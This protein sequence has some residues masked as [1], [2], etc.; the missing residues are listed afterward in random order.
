MSEAQSYDWNSALDTFACYLIGLGLDT[1]KQ[2]NIS[3]GNGETIWEKCALP[4]LH[5][6]Q[7]DRCQQMRCQKLQ[8]KD[9]ICQE[10]KHRASTVYIWQK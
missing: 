10:Q 9:Q 4:S 7:G 1:N 6:S 5:L 2:T 8:E 3:P